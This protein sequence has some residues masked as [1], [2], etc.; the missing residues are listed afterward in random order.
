MK[1]FYDIWILSTS[2]DF[3]GQRISQAIKFTF[4]NRQMP[5]LN[6]VDTFSDSFVTDKQDQWQAFRK[7]VKAM[8]S[9]VNFADV[10]RQVE[11][12]L[13]PIIISLAQ[14]SATPGTWKAPDHWE[15]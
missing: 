13:G 4:E 11:R 2:F 1:D 7:K 12:F 8:E 9:P 15:Q 5:L 14:N 3:V 10:T 6:E